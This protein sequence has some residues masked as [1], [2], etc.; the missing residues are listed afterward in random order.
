MKTYVKMFLQYL[1]VD[2][3][4][5]IK[6]KNGLSVK[7]L[8]KDMYTDRRA[9]IGIGNLRFFIIALLDK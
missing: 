5:N 7:Y 4:T 1:V 6:I 8:G 2:L 3:K 9:D